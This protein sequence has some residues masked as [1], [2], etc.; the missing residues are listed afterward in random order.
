MPPAEGQMLAHH[1][2]DYNPN[3]DPKMSNK[4]KVSAFVG[5]PDECFKNRG[6]SAAGGPITS[7]PS[8]GTP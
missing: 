7:G 1:S 8:M 6:P 3:T 4:K 2:I 5:T